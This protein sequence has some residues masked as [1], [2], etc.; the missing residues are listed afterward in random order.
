MSVPDHEKQARVVN[1]AQKRPSALPGKA[2]FGEA[3][4]LRSVSFI[5]ATTH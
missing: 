2:D 3:G 1:D 4:L 5:Y